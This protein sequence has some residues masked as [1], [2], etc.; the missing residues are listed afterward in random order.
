MIFQ[1]R[2]R[3]SNLLEDLSPQGGEARSSRLYEFDKL[4]FLPLGTEDSDIA[5]KR[6][7]SESLI[8]CGHYSHDHQILEI[9][10]KFKSRPEFKFKSKFKFKFKS[11]FK[12][13]INTKIQNFKFRYPNINPNSI[14]R[15][16]KYNSNY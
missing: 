7:S 4:S 8:S 5:E 9:K 14:P 13:Q 15:N 16:F 11:K 1:K 3:I 6:V 2:P 10:Y 12:L